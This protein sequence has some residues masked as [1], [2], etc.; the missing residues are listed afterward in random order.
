MDKKSIKFY[1]LIF[2]VLVVILG[3]ILFFYSVEKK[4]VVSIDTNR[5]Y[6]IKYTY[7]TIIK[8]PYRGTGIW[9][10][11]IGLTLIIARFLY[12]KREKRRLNNK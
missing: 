4:E 12:D 3:I 11:S 7:Q 6:E 10:F 2:G 5:D 1:L 8:Y 9:I